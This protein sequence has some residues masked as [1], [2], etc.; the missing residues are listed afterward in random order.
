[1]SSTETV[2]D[3]CAV[4]LQ[5]SPRTLSSS[6]LSPWLFL[7]NDDMLTKYWK[8]LSTLQR[9]YVPIPTSSEP[10]I[11]S[12]AQLQA[13]A[14]DAARDDGDGY[15]G[16]DS[17]RFEAARKNEQVSD[18]SPSP[19]QPSYSPPPPPPPA[20]SPTGVD[21]RSMEAL[22]SDLA[23]QSTPIETSIE[24]P[25][26]NAI[27]QYAPRYTKVPSSRI[28]R[29]FHYGGLAA[30]LTYGTASEYLRSGGQRKQGGGNSAFLSEANVD[31]LVSKLSVM[32]GAALKLG[33]FLSIQDS[34]LLPPQIETAL[35]RL[36][37]KADYMPNWQLERVLETELGSNWNE[38]FEDFDKVPIA[39][40]S[41]G[42]VHA[43][44][45]SS[46]HPTHPGMKVALKIQFPGVKESINSDLNNLKILV[47][48]SGILPRGLYLDSTIRVMR[49]ELADECDYIRE[50]ECGERFAEFLAH[51][52][53]FTCP[54]VVKDLCTPNI[55]T[56]QFMTGESLARAYTYDQ[57]TKDKIGSAVMRLCIREI[58]EFKLM[59][60]D[61]NWSNFLWDKETG[62]INLID[63]GASRPY[64][65]DFVDAFGRLLLAAGNG[66]REQC[67][68]S[69]LRLRYLTG[70]ENETMIN[71]HIASMLALGEPFRPSAPNPYPFKNQTITDRVKA[72]IPTMLQHRLTPPPKETYSLNR[73]LSGAFLLCS[74]L[75]SHVSCRDIW[76]EVTRGR[77]N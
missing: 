57:P 5:R 24:A 43:A 33:Q 74:R 50:A 48:A 36:Q 35:A 11:E 76:E 54:V 47:A 7:R 51:D 45:L 63:F 55:L 25:T 71:A 4:E 66:D 21:E 75:G 73:K 42:Q 12:V 53:D 15:D 39:A 46:N 1:M 31:R 60:T 69:S 16:D 38:H 52:P 30:G 68:E 27:P 3:P 65:E 70:E 28:G 49:Q 41:I 6:S 18:P 77:F 17:G 40:A 19:P 56:T 8:T 72:Q 2:L 32:R 22:G 62:K 34:H 29:L 58:F 67:V 23:T 26:E 14:R 20:P 59:Q 61:P 9:I 64:S 44:T 37:N 13:Y 10:S